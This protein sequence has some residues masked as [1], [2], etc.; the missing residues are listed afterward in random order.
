MSEP[1][2]VAQVLNRMDSGGIEAVVMNYYRHIDRSKVQFDFYFVQ[3]SSF[4]QMEEMKRL[5]AGIYPIPPYS[6]VIRYHKELYSAFRKKRYPIVHAH[7]STMSIFPLYAAWRAKVPMRICHNHS[8]AHWG[9]GKKTLL[10]YILRPFNKIFANRWFACGEKAGRWMYGN[11]AFDAG[12]VHVM[13]NAIDVDKYAFDE[14]A[15]KRLRGEL[16]IPEDAFV[17]GHVGRFVY[18][19][20]QPFLVETFEKLKKQK[21]NSV[22]LLIGEGELEESTRG[23]VAEK[24]LD[25][26]VI[27]TGARQDADKLYSAM[28]VFCLPSHYEGMPLVAWE[29]QANGLP[30]VLADCVTREARKNDGC[31]FLSLSLGAQRWSEELLAT[32]RTDRIAVPSIS[33][34]AEQLME[35]YCRVLCVDKPIR[36]AQ[37]LNRM[38]NGGI[39][40]IV[41]D[42]YR[43]IDRSKVQFDFYYAEG[44]RFP[45][46]KELEQLGAGVYP[47]PSYSRVIPYH[48]TLC[49]SFKARKY[50][51]VHAHLSTM[52]VF[53][54]FAAWRAGTPIRIC[55]NHSTAHW[56][57]GKK[58]LL[59]YVLRPFNKL[60]ANQWFACGEWAGRWMYGN[61]AYDAGK[62]HVMPNATDVEKFT[63]DPD[64]R[65]SLRKQL[66][67]TDH[68]P[69]VGHVGRFVYT[70]NQAFLVEV[71]GRLK[72]RM[73]SGVL[74]LVGEGELHDAIFQLVEENG[75]ADSV[76][77][78][79]ARG[80]V[81][82]LYSVMDVFCL[83]RHYEGFGLVAL[84]AQAVGLPCICSKEVPMEIDV[85]SAV[86]HLDTRAE[87]IE[88]WVREIA[89]AIEHS[90]H[91]RTSLPKQYDISCAAAEYQ[92]YIEVKY[93][94][95]YLFA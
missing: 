30:C 86:K 83:P 45:Q 75:L 61:R 76:I 5:G 11:K 50:Q 95:V 66:G 68:A 31:V 74:L 63:F 33:E 8:T 54:L 73:P 49:A 64:A 26:S 69:V 51:I 77:F 89:H 3:G 53:P 47:I 17:V 43:Y 92:D 19:K 24:K 23:I 58:T 2:R 35:S 62:V 71:F 59:K 46:R 38:D 9:E 94:K 57:E 15:R 60:F 88:G 36:V 82:K 84:E 93:E 41:M 40:A 18:P 12:K 90:N 67:I 85:S 80:D 72:Q 79:G 1:I 81:N 65:S 52:S 28:D 91:C 6:H 14:A 29:A 56:G 55:H 42:Y 78:T 7:L 44:S 4:P 70:K 25:D 22:L 20:N 87:D 32:K 37:I 16:G 39:E 13:P 21:Q 34:A 10:K 27:F 48:R